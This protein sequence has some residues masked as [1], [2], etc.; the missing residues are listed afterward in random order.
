MTEQEVMDLLGEGT[1]TGKLA[2]AG[3]SAD[4]HVAPIWFVIDGHDLVFSTGTESVKGRHLRAN[5]RAA[6]TVDVERFPYQ[7]VA[8][9]GEVTVAEDPPDLQRWAT[10]I[11]ERYVPRG[12]AERYGEVN[13]AAG[14][15]LCRLRID[16]L[17]GER[18]I[19]VI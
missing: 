19:A 12:E 7:F 1:H 15:L 13:S 4:P 5:P 14:S 10:R 8:V 3:A 6:L 18:D 2:T 11:A 16:R 9:R 17:T